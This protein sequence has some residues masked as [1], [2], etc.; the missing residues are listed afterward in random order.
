MAEGRKPHP[1]RQ[2]MPHLW[3][4]NDGVAQLRAS[5]LQKGELLKLLPALPLRCLLGPMLHFTLALKEGNLLDKAFGILAS[6]G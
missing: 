4:T 2:V 6:K 5:C 1:F 3:G